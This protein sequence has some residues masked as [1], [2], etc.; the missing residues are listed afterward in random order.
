MMYH[1]QSTINF[2]N[3]EEKETIATYLQLRHDLSLHIERTIGDCIR[4]K[5]SSVVLT[6]VFLDNK[7]E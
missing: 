3:G 6:V 1:I 5:A 4:E 7:G 2:P